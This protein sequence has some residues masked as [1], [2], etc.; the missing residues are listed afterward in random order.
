M[1][2]VGRYLM[3]SPIYANVREEAGVFENPCCL[4]IYFVVLEFLQFEQWGPDG[5]QVVDLIAYIGFS[6]TVPR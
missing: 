6:K 1:Y 5:L 3:P 2:L 4:P